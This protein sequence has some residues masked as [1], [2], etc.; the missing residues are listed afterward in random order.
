MLNEALLDGYRTLLFRGRFPIAVV[1]IILPPEGVDVNVHPSKTL[2]K[3]YDEHL[4]RKAVENS[5][6]MALSNQRIVFKEE[7]KS[8]QIKD[9][10]I[11]YEQVEQITFDVVKEESDGEVLHIDDFFEKKRVPILKV[12]GQ[13]L[14]TYIVADS[15]DGVLLIDQ[16]AA[17]ERIRYEKF[18]SKLNTQIKQELINPIS[19]DIS[20]SELQVLNK[21]KNIIEEVGFEFENFGN[22]MIVI[23]RIPEF[24]K[25]K[26][27]LEIFKDVL[28]ELIDLQD[29][30][31]IHKIK[32]SAVKLI[33][34]KGAIKANQKLSV[35]ELEEL[36]T[37]LSE[38]NNPFTCPHG[39]PIMITITQREL[40]KLFKRKA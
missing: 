25:D 40:E 30:K 17:H 3:F 8:I 13:V 9:S 10:Q 14:D 39:R 26:D 34:C 24:V 1:Y 21:F 19:I 7:P 4:I 38:C 5:V 11:K 31:N 28:M 20:A 33:A 22:D 23:R 2:I 6:Q 15:S 12:I 37:E 32:D 36:L 16:H 18:L 29:I 35:S 27:V